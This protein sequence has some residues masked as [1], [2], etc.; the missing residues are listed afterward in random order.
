MH[1]RFP[2]RRSRFLSMF[3]ERLS[4]LDSKSPAHRGIE[5]GC[6]AEWL[7]HKWKA[8]MHHRTPEL[9]SFHGHVE[10]VCCCRLPR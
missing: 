3:F 2:L 1:R 10:P 6:A 5:S 4:L 9:R 8:V 7:R